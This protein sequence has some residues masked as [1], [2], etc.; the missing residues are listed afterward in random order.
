MTADPKVLLDWSTPFD[1][2][3]IGVLDNVIS[4]MYGGRAQDVS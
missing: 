3:K 4:V 1:A 2:F